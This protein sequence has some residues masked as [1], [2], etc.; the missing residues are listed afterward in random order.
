MDEFYCACDESRELE[1]VSVLGED[2]LQDHCR[3][4]LL[5][6]LSPGLGGPVV[7]APQEPEAGGLQVEDQHEQL[8]ETLSKINVYLRDRNVGQW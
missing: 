7:P 1:P 6:H 4:T 2:S 3:K 8:N 5:E